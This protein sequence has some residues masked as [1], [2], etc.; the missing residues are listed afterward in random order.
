MKGW[1]QDFRF[2]S[3][4]ERG[5]HTGEPFRRRRPMRAHSWRETP[6]NLTTRLVAWWRG[7]LAR[8]AV[9]HLV[10][11][12]ASK[13]ADR[14]A[15]A[16]ARGAPLDGWTADGPWHM[17]DAGSVGAPPFG[18]RYPCRGAIEL[19]VEHG[20]PNEVMQLLLACGAR[21][22]ESMDRQAEQSDGPYWQTLKSRHQQWLGKGTSTYPG[23]GRRHAQFGEWLAAVGAQQRLELAT[24]SAMGVRSGAGR[25]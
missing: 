3:G 17:H 5:W 6:S 23:F 10:W 19:A 18:S 15:R 24:A 7:V 14:V 12:I 16:L 20:V 1:Q 11:A 25:L 4:W 2:R 22:P 8:R 13:R 21:V 9:R